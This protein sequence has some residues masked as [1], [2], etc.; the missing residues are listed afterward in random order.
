MIRFRQLERRKKSAARHRRLLLSF[1]GAASL[2][3]AVSCAEQ[4]AADTED[5]VSAIPWTA[6]E[7]Y[8][9]VI[10]NSDEEPQGE[11]V[12]SVTEDADGNFVLGQ[13]FSD[14]DGNADR[15]VVVADAET[16]RPI[17]GEHTII[18]ASEDRRSVAL[19][20]YELED[21]GDAIVR[22]AGLTYDPA[23]ED[24]PALRC[25][26]DKIDTDHYYDNDTSLFL[27][28]TITFEEGWSAIYT[29]VLSNRRT[30]RT[31]EVRVRRQEKV[32]TPAGEFDAWLVGIAGEG[33]E[34]QSAWFATTPDHKLL[35]YNNREDQIFLYAGEPE[36]PDPELPAELPAECVESD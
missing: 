20:R 6:P 5:V 27:W 25:S 3:V 18:D 4:D 32:T 13:F 30:Q 21:D 17:A 24:D 26:P 11:G 36:Q 28:R 1:V 14:E 22:I 2:L 16:L 19:S 8:R 29:N 34:T 9:Y 33:R 23:D 12:L 15:S 10:V 35:V 7:S 31:L